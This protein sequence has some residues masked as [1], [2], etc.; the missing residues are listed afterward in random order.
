[1]TSSC[2][3]MLSHRK[4]SISPLLLGRRALNRGDTRVA[5]NL[6]TECSKSNSFVRVAMAHRV[7]HKLTLHLYCHT[8]RGAKILEGNKR[9]RGDSP[10]KV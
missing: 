5:R 4:P 1:M 10:I 2:K 9:C 6:R 3:R 7:V 8:V